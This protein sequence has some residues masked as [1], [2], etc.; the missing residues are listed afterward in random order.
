MPGSKM[1]NGNPSLE[2]VQIHNLGESTCYKTG[3][4]CI[5]ILHEYW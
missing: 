1:G 5:E 4:Q 2:K 3:F